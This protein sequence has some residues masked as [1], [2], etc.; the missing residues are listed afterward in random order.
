MSFAVTL[1][2][3][4]EAIW[5]TGRVPP[6]VLVRRPRSSKMRK[7]RRADS[8]DTREVSVISSTEMRPF[9]ASFCKMA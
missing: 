2:G 8:T 4:P 7:S 3:F 6:W 5:R 9:S 1:V